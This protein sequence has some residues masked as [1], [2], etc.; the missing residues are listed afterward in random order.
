M[1]EREILARDSEIR[2]IASNCR[3]VIGI[4]ERALAEISAE[5]IWR[6]METKWEES[7]SAASAE[8]RGAQRLFDFWNVL[9]EEISE[10]EKQSRV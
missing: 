6:R 1:G 3:T 4:E 2:M 5:W 7:F 8:R 9:D 10:N